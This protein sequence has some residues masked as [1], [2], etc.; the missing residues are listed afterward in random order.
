MRSSGLIC[1]LLQNLHKS[2]KTAHLN[3][4]LSQGFESGVLPRS[5][6]FR[7]AWY[8]SAK[9]LA[10]IDHLVKKAFESHRRIKSIHF[11]CFHFP[12]RTKKHRRIIMNR[13]FYDGS[14]MENKIKQCLHDRLF[15]EGKAYIFSFTSRPS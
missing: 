11:S 13:I 3:Q 15:G 8:E 7:D 4:G 2:A 12:C 9:F 6:C 5:D 14:G 1:F 10:N